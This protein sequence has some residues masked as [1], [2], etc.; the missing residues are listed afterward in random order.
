MR[1]EDR[2]C[3]WVSVEAAWPVLLR[4][5][6]AEDGAAVILSPVPRFRG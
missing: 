3:P 6:G 4:V 2:V 5:L 1:L